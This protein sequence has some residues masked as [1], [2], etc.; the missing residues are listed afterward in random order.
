MK[1]ILNRQIHLVL[2]VV[3]DALADP[4]VD[5]VLQHAHQLAREHGAK[6]GKQ[7]PDQQGQV[8]AYQGLVDDASRD[9]GGAAGPQRSKQ[10]WPRRRQ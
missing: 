5:V 1:Y 9:D 10:G 4:R 2:H 7:Q 3:D 8:I 6:G